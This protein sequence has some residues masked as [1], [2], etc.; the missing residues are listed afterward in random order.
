MMWGVL[1]AVVVVIL[2]GCTV[3]FAVI[4]FNQLSL[5]RSLCEEARRQF[6][7]ARSTRRGVMSVFL[8]EGRRNVGHPRMLAP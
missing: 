3:P 4:R 7:A 2:I 8:S 5:G 6:D 1:V